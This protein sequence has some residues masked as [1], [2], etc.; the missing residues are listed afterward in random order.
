MSG[1]LYLFGKRSMKSSLSIS[2]LATFFAYLVFVK[3][4]SV[5]LPPG[6]LKD[7]I[8]LY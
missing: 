4:L 6:I 8:R 7:V 1:A 2:V 3:L 5:P